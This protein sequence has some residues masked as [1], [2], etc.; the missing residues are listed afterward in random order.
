MAFADH[1]QKGG[2]AR[3]QGDFDGVLVC[4]ANAVGSAQSVI[5]RAEAHI[6]RAV[7]LRLLGRLDDAQEQFSQVVEALGDEP[8]PTLARCYRDYGMLL[9]E[10]CT[11]GCFMFVGAHDAL[12]ASVQMYQELGDTIEAQISQGFLGRYYLVMEDRR[13]AVKLLRGTHR[14]IRSQDDSGER[15]NLVW[16]ASA[17]LFWRWWYAPRALKITKGTRRRKEYLILLVGGDM[18]YVWLKARQ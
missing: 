18:L 11:K 3:Q 14:A 4:Y 2:Q 8:S 15:D 16:L 9:L 10:R 1:M 5:D 7:T 12:T 13:M 17:S 6:Q